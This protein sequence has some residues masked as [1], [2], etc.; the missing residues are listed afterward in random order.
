ML[1][2][3]LL[4]LRDLQPQLLVLLLDQH[5]LLALPLLLLQHFRVPHHVLD[6]VQVLPL[7]VLLPLV[8]LVLLLL[9]LDLLRQLLYPL[10]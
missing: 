8:V 2:D 6:L 3:L 1:L 7:L 4:H 9:L 10:H 5:Q